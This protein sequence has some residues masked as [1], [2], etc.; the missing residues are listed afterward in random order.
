MIYPTRMLANPDCP[1]VLSD[2]FF[3][4]LDDF[5]M[6]DKGDDVSCLYNKCGTSIVTANNDVYAQLV[7]KMMPDTER[8]REEL[9]DLCSRPSFS[10]AEGD[11]LLKN[12]WGLS[13][14]L[15]N[16]NELFDCIVD[17]DDLAHAG[18]CNEA[19][20]ILIPFLK[21]G[22]LTENMYRYLFSTFQKIFEGEGSY[23]EYAFYCDRTSQHEKKFFDFFGEI[24]SS[25][26][27]SDDDIT[28]ALN[29]RK[30]ARLLGLEDPHSELILSGYFHDLCLVL[31]GHPHWA[32]K[33][34]AEYFDLPCKTDS[35]SEDYDEL[36]SHVLLFG[37][38]SAEDNGFV[39][40]RVMRSSNTLSVLALS[41]KHTQSF[42][43]LTQ[44]ELNDFILLNSN[45]NK[46]LAI[47]SYQVANTPLLKSDRLPNAAKAIPNIYKNNFILMQDMSIKNIEK[48]TNEEASELA[49]YLSDYNKRISSGY[50]ESQLA[51]DMNFIVENKQL[52]TDALSKVIESIPRLMG[53]NR[54]IAEN[55]CNQ[56]SLTGDQIK[57]LANMVGG[58]N[59]RFHLLS[60][61]NCPLDLLIEIANDKGRS[62]K[63]K[64]AVEFGESLRTL[65]N[66]E[67]AHLFNACLVN[68][69]ELYDK[70]SANITRSSLDSSMDAIAEQ[71]IA[72]EL[73]GK[74]LSGA[75]TKQPLEY[76]ILA[77]A[78]NSLNVTQSDIDLLSEI[79]TI[80]DLTE[81]KKID[82][83][84]YIPEDLTEGGLA[85]TLK[86]KATALPHSEVPT[87]PIR[88]L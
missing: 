66:E 60:H 84:V 40:D 17:D 45:V 26:L 51:R 76:A 88:Q 49:E 72:Y 82:E 68:R 86:D 7:A 29:L 5:S 44:D 50:T 21:N 16:E 52:P 22:C 71:Y 3:N 13:E 11:A 41:E 10:Q 30:E 34:F 33:I 46:A 87:K 25:S 75:P 58:S 53:H 48:I 64:S 81:L 42:D 62:D 63:F 27:A 57:S 78:F 67:Y 59:V 43:F 77:H 9:F 70:C 39:F 73:Y 20:T 35:L 38:L 85:R 4:N 79:L 18:A 14:N 1:K 32:E 65:K 36:F 54:F 55:I 47:Q 23:S 15:A 24:L 6:E 12:I 69:D 28:Y 74:H 80:N 83:D 61:K 2:W 8:Q 19:L 31:K 37:N 56:A